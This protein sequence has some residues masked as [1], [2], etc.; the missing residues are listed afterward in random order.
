MLAAL[1][2]IGGAAVAVAAP[3]SA[4][5]TSITCPE[6]QTVFIFTTGIITD[7]AG[8]MRHTWSPNGSN[9]I[10]AGTQDPGSTVVLTS[11][12]NQR[13]VSDIAVTAVGF[14]LVGDHTSVQC[15]GVR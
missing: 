2:V 8:F 9:I 15:H 14:N 4:Y 11:Q 6:G 7:Q 12:T 5:P 3:A 10:Y 13:S 1:A